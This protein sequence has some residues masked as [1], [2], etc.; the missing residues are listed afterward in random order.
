MSPAQRLMGG[1]TKS[2]LPMKEGLLKPQNDKAFE[3]DRAMKEEQRARAAEKQCNVK[4][5]KML[6]INDTVKMLRFAPGKKE[7]V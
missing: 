6:N 1:R 4:E 2:L 7:W 3:A 5:L